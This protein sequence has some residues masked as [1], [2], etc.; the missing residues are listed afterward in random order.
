[1]VKSDKKGNFQSYSLFFIPCLYFRKGRRRPYGRPWQAGSG[2]WAVVWR[3][4]L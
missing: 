4:L 3:P 2:P 1:M